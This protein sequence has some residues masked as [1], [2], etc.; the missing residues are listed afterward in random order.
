MHSSVMSI[1]W[2]AMIGNS[3]VTQQYSFHQSAD[4]DATHM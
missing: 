2:N 3:Y 1:M 4:N